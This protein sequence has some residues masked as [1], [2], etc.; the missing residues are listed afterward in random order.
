MSE[1]T[2]R[3]GIYNTL[4]AV[5]DIGMV[6]DYERWAADW[7]KFIDFFKTT[8]G[9]IDQ[10]RGW[11]I[12]QKAPVNEDRTS[13]KRRTYAIKGYMSVN[14]ALATEKTF[15]ALIDAIAAKFRESQ[16]LD[17]TVKGHDFIQVEMIEP[18]MFGGVLC[19]CAELTLT[20]YDFIG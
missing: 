19:H 10:I 5:T 12:S 15:A 20:V 4:A 9:G 8:I 6:Y 13:I 18:R 11:E 7:N 2:N 1:A 14:D 3:A 17:G 16:T